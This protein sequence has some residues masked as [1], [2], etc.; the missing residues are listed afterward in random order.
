MSAIIGNNIQIKEILKA[1]GYDCPAGL[2]GKTFNEATQG[3]GGGGSEDKLLCYY[4]YNGRTHGDWACYVVYTD[5]PATR[6]VYSE[7]YEDGEEVEVR[8]NPVDRGNHLFLFNINL[9]NM[10]QGFQSFNLVYEDGS[11]ATDLKGKFVEVS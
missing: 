3:G 9:S 2:E 7:L 4:L 10:T 5:K 11:P 1:T 8:V 6:I